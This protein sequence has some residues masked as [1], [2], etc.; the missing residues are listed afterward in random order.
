ME[1][2]GHQSES[3]LE[4]HLR[5]LSIFH[6]IVGG[7]GFLVS[8]FPIF[9]F[10]FGIFMLFSDSF[11]PAEVDFPDDFPNKIFGGAMAG[12]AGLMMLLGFILS[13]LVIFAGRK[14]ARRERRI[15]CIVIAGI[16]CMFA[17][18]GTALGI[19]TII[20]LTKPESRELF[21]ET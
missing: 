12:I 7:L 8:L 18:F 9:H 15:F 14:I 5:L 1:Q 10:G 13:S 21:N 6:Y 3:Q 19:F 4:E 17:P 20:V 2:T 11:I 16:L